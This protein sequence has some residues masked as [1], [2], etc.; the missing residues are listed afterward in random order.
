MVQS[1]TTT[2]IRLPCL[3][4]GTGPSRRTFTRPGRRTR[5]APTP[6][7]RW[8]DG[9]KCP[10][11]LRRGGRPHHQCRNARPDG[12]RL[13]T[14]GP[15]PPP[16]H[17]RADLMRSSTGRHCRYTSRRWST[18]MTTTC[19]L[20]SSMRYRTRYSPRRARHNPSNG[21]RSAAPTRRGALRSGPLMNSHAAKAAAVGSCSLSARRAPSDSTTEYR[22]S[23]SSALPESSGC[24]LTRPPL[25]HQE[26]HFLCAGG[27]A[28][29]NCGL[30][31]ADASNRRWI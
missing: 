12:R 3:G 27:L 16:T 30:R 8:H 4:R 2:R 22:G 24:L 31:L 28:P 7:N 14:H 11:R 20:S 10:A 23:S 17:P 9:S 6:P 19:R 29:L 15:V 21:A 13:R 25:R 26:S 1:Y 18:S 5:L